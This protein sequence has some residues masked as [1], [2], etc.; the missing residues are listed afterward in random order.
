M[1]NGNGTVAGSVCNETD[2][3]CACKV[4]VQN[5]LCDECKDTFYNLDILNP[6]GCQRKLIT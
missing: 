2:G 4:N 3:S 5:L 1:C 6:A